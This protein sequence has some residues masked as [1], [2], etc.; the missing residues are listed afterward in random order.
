M[1]RGKNSAD[2]L[3]KIPPPKEV[4]TP[5]TYYYFRQ[6]DLAN[7]MPA[8]STKNYTGN[9]QYKSL[10]HSYKGLVFPYAWTKSPLILMADRH[11]CKREKPLISVIAHATFLTGKPFCMP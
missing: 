5:S 10:S 7:C 4:T 2:G 8:G 9:F 1:Q 6:A 11:A 3:R